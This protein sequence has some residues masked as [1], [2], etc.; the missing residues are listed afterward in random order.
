MFF[1]N[2]EP[3]VRRKLASPIREKIAKTLL[4]GTKPTY[5]AIKK[6]EKKVLVG[7]KDQP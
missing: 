1:F 5:D 3:K 2:H 7:C 6:K 4:A